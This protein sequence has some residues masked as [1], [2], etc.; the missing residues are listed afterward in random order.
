V[1]TK[2]DVAR[3]EIPAAEW[4]GRDVILGA[5]IVGANGKASFWSNFVTVTVLPAPEKPVDVMPVATAAGVKLTWHAQ[6][7]QFRVFRTT[8][9]VDVATAAYLDL[10]GSA[11]PDGEQLDGR[12]FL[13]EN[14]D[15]IGAIGYWRSGELGLRQWLTSLRRVDEAAG[16]RDDPSDAGCAAN[17]LPLTVIRTYCRPSGVP[18]SRPHGLR[19]TPPH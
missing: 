5:R 18:W 7:A 13:V 2:G 17:R 16:Y 14:Y 10:T 11:I 1:P 3:Y 4:T 9:G 12:A 8:A 19:Y 15:P 6:G